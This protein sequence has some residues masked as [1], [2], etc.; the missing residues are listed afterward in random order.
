V[1]AEFHRRHVAAY[2][3]ARSEPLSL[4]SLD[5]VGLARMSSAQA[6]RLPD[7]PA[8]RAGALSSRQIWFADGCLEA[9]AYHRSE[10]S[11][12]RHVSG[13]AVIEQAD[14]TTIV[15]PDWAGAADDHGNL[16]LRRS[17]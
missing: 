7:E 12:G 16:I 8:G 9:G 14:T 5:V 6:P 4:F 2:G 17:R 11:D 13:P 1:D 10:L 15:P 3:Y